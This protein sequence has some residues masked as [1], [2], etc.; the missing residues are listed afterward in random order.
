MDYCVYITTYSGNKLPKYYVGSSSVDKVL[1]GYRGTVLSKNYKKIWNEELKQNPHLFETEI[2][3]KH[4]TRT[5]ALT[6]EKRI[7]IKNDVVKSANWI[8]MAYAAPNGFFGRDTSRE[9]HPL[10]QI[11]HTD[12]TRKKISENHHDVK[13]SNN[14]MFGKTSY[15]VIDPEGNEHFILAGINKW[16]KDRNLNYGHIRAVAM[17]ERNHHKK[18]TARIMTQEEKNLGLGTIIE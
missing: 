9:N 13:G 10:Y 3:S 7:Q 2:V 18:H 11:G 1:E 5:E 14:P 12:E 15:V 8:N 17:G 6:E 4:S 16:C